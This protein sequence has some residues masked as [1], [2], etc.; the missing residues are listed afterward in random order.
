METKQ[1]DARAWVAGQ[2]GPADVAQVAREG[3]KVLVC[4]RPDH[5]HEP[6]QPAFADVA[7]AAQAAGIEARLIAFGGEGPAPGQAEELAHLLSEHEGK[8]LLYCRS[9]ARSAMLYEIARTMA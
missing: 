6:D 1:I 4:N 3:F 5:E 9:G 2:I 8:V 7:A